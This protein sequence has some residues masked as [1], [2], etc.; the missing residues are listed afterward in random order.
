MK[1]LWEKENVKK[2]VKNVNVNENSHA[3]VKNEEKMQRR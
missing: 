1:I 3:V 2:R